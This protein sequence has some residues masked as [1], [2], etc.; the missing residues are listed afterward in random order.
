MCFIS[1]YRVYSVRSY[2]IMIR[3]CKLLGYC[4]NETVYDW[5]FV[6]VIRRGLQH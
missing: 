1:M 3:I 4:T 6:S 5:L 2:I